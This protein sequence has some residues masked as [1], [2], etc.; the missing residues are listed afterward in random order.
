LTAAE[1]IAAVASVVAT[2]NGDTAF[3]I[4]NG[5][6]YVFNNSTAG[7]VV[8]QLVAQTGATSLLTTNAATNLAIH[9]M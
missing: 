8:V 4:D 9:I 2:T 5:S 7:D 6:T 1:K 3:W